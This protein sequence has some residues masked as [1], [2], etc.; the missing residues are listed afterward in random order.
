MSPEY[1]ALQIRIPTPLWEA[2][3]LAFPG[4]GQRRLLIERFIALAIDNKDNQDCFIEMLL[5]GEE[6]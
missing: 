6:V 2:F 1:K 5:E 3:Y 4:K